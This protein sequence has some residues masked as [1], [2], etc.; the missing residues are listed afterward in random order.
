MRFTELLQ[1]LKIPYRAEGHEHCR[2]GWLQLDCPFCGKIGHYRMGYSLR[3]GY[4]NCWSCGSRRLADTIMAITGLAYRAVRVLLTD[5][6]HVRPVARPEVRGTLKLPDMVG[7]LGYAHREYL[8]GRGFR[9]RTIERLWR[10]RGIGIATRL[11]WR[12]FIPIIYRAETV[13]WTTRAIA[14]GE[15]MRYRSAAANEE[16]RNHKELLYGWD[17]VRQACIIV[18]GPLDAWAIGPGAVA[19]C[20]T[21][22]SRRQLLEMGKAPIRAV[23]FD[24]D[25]PAQQRARRLCDNLMVMPGTTTNVVLDAKDAAAA[26]KKDIALL[27][28]TFLD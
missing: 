21:A 8:R 22:Y 26:P 20:G 6:D 1:T 25:R 3:G 13:S 27:R 11:A 24:N 18:E 19:T 28:K 23:C 10:V 5:V 7:P 17:Y 14:A 12:L 15:S 9:P 4:V 2:P 16:A